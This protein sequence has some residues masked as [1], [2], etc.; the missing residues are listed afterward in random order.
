MPKPGLGGVETP[1]LLDKHLDGA[2]KDVEEIVFCMRGSARE[3]HFFATTGYDCADPSREWFSLGPGALMAMNLRTKEVRTILD[4]PK[5]AVRSPCVSYDGQRILFSW[6]RDESKVFHLYEI[7]A[8]GTGLRQI[9]DGA[10]D[11][12]EPVY[13]PDGGIVFSSARCKRFVPCFRSQVQMLYRCELDGTGIR[14]LSAGQENELTPWVLPDGRVIYM[15]WE[16]VERQVRTYH[17]LWTIRPDGTNEMVYFGNNSKS[18]VS[19]PGSVVIM[20]AKPIPGTNSVV[21]VSHNKHGGRNY[22]GAVVVIDPSEG[23]DEWDNLLNITSDPRTDLPDAR[24]WRDPYPLSRD[25]FILALENAIYIMDGKGNFEKIFEGPAML[26]E[27]RPLTARPR[28]TELPSMVDPSNPKATCMIADVTIGRNMEG[29]DPGDVKKMMILEVLPKPISVS[30]GV[31]RFHGNGSNLKRIIGTVPVEPDGSVHFEAP[32]MRALMF[33]LLDEKDRAIKRMRSFTTFMPGEQTSC[34]GCHERRTLI[35]APQR[36]TV[37]A[38]ER[39]PS[40]P[41][42]PVGSPPYGIVD[43]MRDLQPILDK[44]CVKCH[45]PLSG[46]L[47]FSGGVMPDFIHGYKELSRIT[48]LG[49]QSRGNDPPYKFG[50]GNSKLLDMLEAGHHK[51]QLSEAE[52]NMFRLWIDTGMWMT[53]THANMMWKDRCG[54][55]ASDNPKGVE[56]YKA[57]IS[58][59]ILQRRCDSCHEP[60]MSKKFGKRRKQIIDNDNLDLTN[61][62]KSL[63]LLAPLAK[64]AGGLGLCRDKESVEAGKGKVFA[65]KGDPDYVTLKKEIEQIREIA[66]P[67]GFHW[68]PGFK[69]VDMYIR[70]MKR[71]GVLPE[72]FD[73]DTP[74][75]PWK[76]DQQYYELF[77]P[78]HEAGLASGK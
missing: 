49:G 66:F 20:D 64:D 31:R 59:D 2:L 8:D 13:V 70:E 33:V 32:A 19:V 43:Y 50:S 54:F 24:K 42:L 1:G 76:T 9:T 58:G 15:R 26:H 61:V 21:A 46:N 38:L 17:H 10:F 4:D 3:W 22:T 5:G 37:M 53:G 48:P 23:P 6:R 36:Q 55:A 77:Y 25:C 41:E 65:T 52:F 44:H 16:Y 28:E 47:N 78:E 27:P 51:V 30:G 29:I 56:N 72:E 67:G 73:P 74:L 14:A 45:N 60:Q 12:V 62:E 39:Y 68:K 75:D 34:I 40:K 18:Y 71:Y 63:L 11:D 69:P 57:V 7:N 35:T